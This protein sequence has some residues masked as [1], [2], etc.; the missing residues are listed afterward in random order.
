M[1]ERYSPVLRM[2]VR[3]PTFTLSTSILVRNWPVSTCAPRRRNASMNAV[4][5]GSATSAGAAAVQLG[6]R[7]L[8]VSPYRVNWLTTRIG[9]PEVAA[10]PNQ[11]VLAWLLHQT[12]PVIVPLIGPRTLAQYE[13]ALPALDVILTD[14]QLAR[15]DAA[16]A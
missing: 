10:P 14:A 1:S 16:G 12:S 9:A 13:V 3:G 2:T 15:L 7:P 5:R 11:V 8:R 6:R 4:T